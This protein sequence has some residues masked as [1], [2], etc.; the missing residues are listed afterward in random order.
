MG[1]VAVLPEKEVGQPIEGANGY[2][3]VNLSALARNY[4][5]LST[6]VAPA[7]AAAVVKADAYGLGAQR[8]CSTLYE[9]GCRHF[10]VAQFDEAVELRP[11]LAAD[12]KV[13]VLNG[14]QPGNEEACAQS[15]IIPVLNSLE[16]WRRWS[17]TAKRRKCK[18][19][20]VLQFDTGMSRLG[21]PPEER[22]TLAAELAGQ[23]SVEIL[24]IMSHLASA[25]EFDS[26]QNN[27]Q[28]VE[29]KRISKE[30]PHLK[31]C[32]ANSG[33]IFLGK[34]YHGQV[35]RT[36]IALYG[37][38]P[39][40]GKPNPMA[41]VV[42]LD[43]AVVQTRTVPAGAKVGYSG[44]HVTN[45]DTRLATIAAGY[46][47]GLPRSLSGRGAVYYEGRRLPIVGRVSMDSITIDITA[48]PEG[49][50]S[51]G[52]LVEVVGTHQTLEDL[53]RDAGTIAYEVL[54]G[55]GNRYHRQY[56]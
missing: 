53:A 23:V 42:E 15:D 44:A 7:Q 12:A 35:A 36:G 55:L 41:P 30:F 25:D 21:V 6:L 19:Q 10:F 5:K 22:S 20:A 14:L 26:D 56:R 31:I 49:T 40:I 46:A 43:V 24:F 34:N 4:A 17:A 18:L 52:S 29:M 50:L 27:D 13:F 11:A 48:L 39:S 1:S 51:L 8:V 38:S 28:L 37:G 54:T 2:L 47:D 3:T 45:R 9:S 33:G 32:F 16:Q